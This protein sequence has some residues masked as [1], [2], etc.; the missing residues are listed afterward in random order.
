MSFTYCL[1]K[2]QKPLVNDLL[3]LSSI[4]LAINKI[5]WDIQIHLNDRKY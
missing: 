2:R 5:I 3:N 4:L 1:C